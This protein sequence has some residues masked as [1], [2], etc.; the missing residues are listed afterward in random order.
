MP[1][2]FTPESFR[3]VLAN[4]YLKTK[5]SGSQL[6]SIAAVNCACRF[7]VIF[8]SVLQTAPQVLQLL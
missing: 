5:P 3:V 8:D 6:Q 1:Q 7:H 2:C 4:K